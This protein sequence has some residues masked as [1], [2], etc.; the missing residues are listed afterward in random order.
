MVLFVKVIEDT[1]VLTFNLYVF[2]FD[3]IVTSFQ[4]R[5][6]LLLCNVEL[7]FVVFS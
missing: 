1:L 6:N 3:T 2:V 5:G 7:I 4:V